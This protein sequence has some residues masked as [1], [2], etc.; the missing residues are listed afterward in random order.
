MP[1]VQ[2]SASQNLVGLQMAVTKL[3][4]PLVLLIHWLYIEDFYHPFSGFDHL[5]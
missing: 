5:L 4:V 3:R 1:Q 2:G